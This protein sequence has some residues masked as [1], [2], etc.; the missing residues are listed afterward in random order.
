MHTDVLTMKLPLSLYL[1]SKDFAV[2]L[3]EVHFVLFSDEIYDA[4]VKA[5]NEQL[6][7]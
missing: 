4:W 7:N 1:L 3:K 6:Q 5:A 2:D